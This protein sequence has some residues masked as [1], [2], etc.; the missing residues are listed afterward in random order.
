MNLKELLVERCRELEQLLPSPKQIDALDLSR[1]LRQLLADKHSLVNTA[2]EQKVPIRF[3][4]N[5]LGPLP[6]GGL[7]TDSVL[8][9]DGLDPDT[10]APIHAAPVSLGLEDFLK[11]VV[12]IIE[13]KERSI[14]DVIKFGANVAGGVHHD[15]KPRHEY[16]DIQ[17][18]SSMFGVGGLPAGIRQLKAISRVTLKALQPLLD[19]IKT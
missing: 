17:A 4:V 8:L 7:S 13:G 3:V 2:N 6:P 10:S 1:V 5:P 14:K 15:P 19:S 16:K 12:L 9:G 11:H 18:F